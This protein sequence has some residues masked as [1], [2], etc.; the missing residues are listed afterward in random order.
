MNPFFSNREHRRVLARGVDI[1]EE[2]PSF[3]LPL[4]EV[5]IGGKTV[6][7]L[8]P[9]GRLPFEASIMVSLPA[10]ARGIHMSRMEAAVSS[11]H[12]REFPDLQAYTTELAQRVMA[13][14]RSTECSVHLDGKLPLPRQT[15]VSNLLSIDTVDIS[16]TTEIDGDQGTR[17]TIGVAI[18]HLTACP[19]TL[20]YNQELFELRESPCPLAT[21]SQRSRT[22]LEIGGHGR[23]AISH[24][25]LVGCL[26]AALH[27]AHDLLKR[28]DEA[29]LVLKAHLQPQFA[30]DAVRETA[31]GAGRMFADVLPPETMVRIC[32]VSLE[33]IHIH[34]VR[35][36][37]T[38][39]LDEIVSLL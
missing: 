19:C 39:S 13:D 10:T 18:C 5:G 22:T 6:W 31:R 16:A 28:P 25:D 35:C 36:S 38:S 17:T 14:Q 9:Q 11:L 3:P 37:V 33:S 2:Q 8:L 15:P 29:E 7:V 30:E 34:D 4:N 23:T 21:H 1:P 27:S 20:S 24:A 32:S 26:E 12:H